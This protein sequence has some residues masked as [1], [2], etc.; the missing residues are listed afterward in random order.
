M[1]DLKHLLDDAAGPEPAITDTDL[2]TDLARGRRAVRRRRIAGVAT[3]TVATAA[4][5]GAAWSFLPGDGTPN[6]T[7]PVAATI[8]TPSATGV[9][10]PWHG[11]ENK[12]LPPRPTVPVALV[13]N[14][15]PMPGR[16]TCDLIPQ[17]WAV[18]LTYPGDKGDWESKQLYDPS[19]ANPGQFGKNTIR[20]IVRES[21]LLDQGQGLV[22]DK[23]TQPWAEQPH[24]RAG[25][26]EAVISLGSSPQ[27][28]QREV[29]VRQGKTTRVV[30][31]ANDAYNLAWDEATLLKFAGSCRYK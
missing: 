25:T 26:K 27:D 24:V 14:T 4:V 23:Y 2:D 11:P 18:K 15:Q 29:H 1:T 16:I 30:V 10:V 31:V 28:G 3:G 12:P 17:G 22:A 21:E 5:I 6:T 19:L 20:L 13:A 8:S 9:A 7:P